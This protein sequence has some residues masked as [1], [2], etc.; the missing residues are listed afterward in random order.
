MHR[1]RKATWQ[2]NPHGGIQRKLQHDRILGFI[3]AGGLPT[4]HFQLSGDVGFA[5][6]PTRCVS[7]PALFEESIIMG[8]PIASTTIVVV[9]LPAL[10]HN[11]PVLPVRLRA[12][13]AS[14]MP[15]A[16]DISLCAKAGSIHDFRASKLRPSIFFITRALAKLTT[17]TCVSVRAHD[18]AFFATNGGSAATEITPSNEPIPIIADTVPM[19]TPFLEQYARGNGRYDGRAAP[20][21]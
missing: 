3:T 21:P 10:P 20:T 6:K 12:A 14:G 18:P 13:S 5:P 7:A 16:S 11:Q 2:R 19:G 1:D 9:I 17:C 8:S 15:R 4:R